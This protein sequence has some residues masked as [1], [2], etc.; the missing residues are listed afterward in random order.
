MT[1]VIPGI[2]EKGFVDRGHSLVYLLL[3]HC[4]SE[5]TVHHRFFSIPLCLCLLYPKQSES[6]VLFQK[7]LFQESYCLSV[8]VVVIS[9]LAVELRHV[10]LRL[11]GVL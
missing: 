5:M 11:D 6:R 1:A 10:D 4:S 7:R 3:V 9:A 2:R 8:S